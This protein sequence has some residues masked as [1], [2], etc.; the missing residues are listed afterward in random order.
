MRLQSEPNGKANVFGLEKP[1]KSTAQERVVKIFDNH[2]RSLPFPRDCNK[3]AF[4][5]I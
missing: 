5:D 3:S 4:I 2:R 1:T